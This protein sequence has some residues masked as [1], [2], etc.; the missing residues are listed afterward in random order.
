MKATSDH[1]LEGAASVP[2][3]PRGS[4][5][6]GMRQYN[7]RVVL[8]ALRMHG[9]LPKAELAR[10]TGLTAQTIGLITT[11]LEED[12][13]FSGVEDDDPS[14]FLTLTPVDEADLAQ[15]I[16]GEIV[17]GIDPDAFQTDA[18]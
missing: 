15:G 10:V 8:Q 11:R 7:E 9:A 3:R 1:G 2:L 17:V 16:T 12:G 14:Y 5:Q 13:V 18:A 6:L 4:N